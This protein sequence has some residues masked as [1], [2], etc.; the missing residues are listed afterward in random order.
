MSF[1]NLVLRNRSYRRFDASQPLDEET[2]REL[3]A[4]ARLAPSAA[5][6]QPL[7]YVLSCRP[8]ENGQIYSTLTWAGA[9][10]GWPGLAEEDRPTGYI[11]VLT[12]RALKDPADIDVGIAAQTILLAAAERGLGGCMVSSVQRGRLRELL[13]LPD[14]LAVSLVIALGRPA[15]E[16]VLEDAV[17]GGSTRYWRDGMQVHHVPKRVLGELIVRVYA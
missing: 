11:V 8:C 4:V 3:I 6:L 7:R 13:G 10:K 17:P 15:E 14:G 16:V 1:R 5:N 2:L 9:L 12:D